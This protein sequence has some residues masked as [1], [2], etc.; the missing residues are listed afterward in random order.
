MEVVQGL[1]LQVGQGLLAVAVVQTLLHAAVAV[2]GQEG[3]GA[4]RQGV[5]RYQIQEVSATL[6][7]V[8][9]EL[10]Q[11][12]REHTWAVQVVLGYTGLAGAA[13]EGFRDRGLAAQVTG[14]QAPEA[15]QERTR[16]VGAVAGQAPARQEAPGGLGTVW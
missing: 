15:P 12:V 14:T 13:V 11:E 4:Q 8:V 7:G 1:V 9:M 2:A 3:L 6:L 16:V 5:Q 10:L